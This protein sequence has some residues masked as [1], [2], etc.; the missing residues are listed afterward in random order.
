MEQKK[1]FGSVGLANLNVSVSPFSPFETHTQMCSDWGGVP[2]W[3]C[4]AVQRHH[5]PRS[6]VDEN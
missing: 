2:A 3:C 6:C 4:T 5:Q 1:V